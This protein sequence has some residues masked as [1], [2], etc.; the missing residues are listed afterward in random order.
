MIGSYY[1]ETVEEEKINGIYDSFGN[2]TIN[3]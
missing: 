3:D 1:K 2:R